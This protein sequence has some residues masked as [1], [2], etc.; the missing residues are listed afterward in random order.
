MP[1]PKALGT[2]DDVCPLTA[3]SGKLE[4]AFFPTAAAIVTA[5]PSDVWFKW[6]Q[7]IVGCQLYMTAVYNSGNLDCFK[8]GIAEFLSQQK[9]C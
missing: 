1:Q 9:Y 8:M 3:A 2:H 6:F 5:S 4:K 7:A